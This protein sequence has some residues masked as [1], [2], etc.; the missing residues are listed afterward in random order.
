MLSVS[1]PTP[2]G[3]ERLGS[4]PMLGAQQPHPGVAP[5]DD[6]VHH[7]HDDV[8]DYRA[9]LL[10]GLPSERV[11]YGQHNFRLAMFFQILGHGFAKADTSLI[12]REPVLT[13]G[14]PSFPI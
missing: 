7:V 5:A 13:N 12:W 2:A 4:K 3:T 8:L 14:F 1:L 11:K 9:T 10:A 6:V